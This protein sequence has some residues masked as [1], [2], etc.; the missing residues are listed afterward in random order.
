[1][2]LLYSRFFYKALY[3]MALVPTP[4]PFYGRN[5]RGFILGPDGAK[6]SK[7]KGN[8]VNPD[9]YVQKHGSDALRIYLAFMGPYNEPGSYP[10]KPEGVESMR[11]FL[12]RIYALRERVGEGDIT[13]EEQKILARTAAKLRQ[14][15]ARLKL[16]TAVS[17]LM[18][19]LNS[20]EAL[21]TMSPEAFK[22][23]IEFLAPFAPHLA[24]HLYTPGDLDRPSVHQQ[25]WP[26]FHESLLEQETVVIGV[27]VA[28][29]RRAEVS[30][31]PS[32][33]E[34]EAVAEA[35]KAPNIQAAIPNGKPS[36]VIYVPGRILNL[37]P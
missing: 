4:E 36:R 7:S 30:L 26:V 17:S 24:E 25:E 9:E 28:G 27:Q 19:A 22:I 31:S 16:N 13:D 3:D 21:D 18:V 1:M 35:L 32:A 6:M 37:I 33:S 2:H 10:W 29:K 5:N 34:D 20:F 11:R 15:M 23:Y 14:D 8:V 12:D